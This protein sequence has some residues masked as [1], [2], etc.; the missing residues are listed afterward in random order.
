MEGTVGFK[1]YLSDEEN[2]SK[3]EVRRFGIDSDVVTNF[4][5]LRKKLENIFPSVRGK[6]YIINWKDTDGDN[7]V[8]SSDEELQI[9]LNETTIDPVRKLYIVLKSDHDSQ[10]E[11]DISKDVEA[12]HIGVTCDGCEQPVHGF[13]FKCIQCPD[14]DLCSKCQAQGMHGEH[15][16]LRLISPGQWK[17]HYGKR[18]ARHMHKFVRKSAMNKEEEPKQESHKKGPKH[19]GRSR[20]CPAADTGA[21]WIDT[22]A[23]Y[24][25]EFA[26]LPGECPMKNPTATEE[27][28]MDE[29]STSEPTKNDQPKAS[30]FK[31]LDPHVELLK[32]VGQNLAHF[33]DPLGI[34][35]SIQEKTDQTK[36]ASTV[37]DDNKA[38]APSAPTP[39]STPPSSQADGLE[40]NGRKIQT[41]S[42]S[43]NEAFLTEKSGENEEWTIITPNTNSAASSGT[44]PKKVA[45]SDKSQSPER[46]TPIYPE[47][48]KPETT[49]YHPNKKIQK[50]IETMMQ[51]GFSNEGGWLTNLLESKDGDIVG[52]LDA[53]QRR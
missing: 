45:P 18:L 5:Y 9:A 16:M 53:L 20:H 6:R 21:S 39:T 34:D 7:I 26:N 36:P 22:I 51:M 29:P 50:A 43:D 35:V 17:P 8:I 38:T 27:K 15:C 46:V 44:I 30:E 49:I 13:R 33:L 10:V 14:Y 2:S 28:S 42:P 23:S 40:K 19:H 12:L 25:N 11:S 1:V 32:M 52:A 47:L 24:L 3:Q 31:K 48:P 4:L 41:P 37:P